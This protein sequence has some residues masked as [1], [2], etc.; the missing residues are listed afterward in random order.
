MKLALFGFGGHAREVQVQMQKDLTFF[1][2]DS[3]HDPE[4][5]RGKK[6]K[7][8]KDFDPSVYA[9]MLAVGDSQKRKEIVERLPEET[10]YFT[11]IHPTAIIANGSKI[12]H[13]SFVGAF[14]IITNDVSVG[15]HCILNRANHIGH[16]SKIGNFFSAMPGSIVSG[17][18]T[19]GNQVYLGTN[20][21]VIEGKI[22]CDDIIIGAGAVVVK[23]L[24]ESG[25]YVGVPARMLLKK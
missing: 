17:D 22:L 12:G 25:T 19:I 3:F 9:L 5:Y 8:L 13:G 10:R 7:P 11:Y 18:V 21:S 4:K 15:E 24:K 20:S 23:N 16:N 14:S 6:V 2:D 1:I